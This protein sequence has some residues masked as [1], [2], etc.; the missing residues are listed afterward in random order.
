MTASL[1]KLFCYLIRL[2]PVR[3]AGAIG[4]GIGRTAYLLDK[5]HREIAL[6]NLRR[7]YPER[8][9][10]WRRHIARESFAELGRTMFELPHV[11]L[12]S[13]AFLQSRI[14]FDQKGL[15]EIRSHIES[16][17]GVIFAGCH[18]ANWE[19]GA[20]IPSLCDLPS[21]QLYRTVRQ[22]P[23]EKLMKAWRERFGN[24]LHSRNESIRWLPKAL[25]DGNIVAVM[26]DQHIS[27]GVPI[28]FLGHPANS[29][30]MPAI[31]ARK[32]GT[33]IFAGLFQ[34]VG[35]DFRFRI[36]FKRVELPTTSDD[37]DR[38][39]IE[40]TRLISDSFADTIHSKPEQWL[41][42]H[43]RWLFL[44]EKEAEGAQ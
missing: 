24:R 23:L 2:L 43:R 38:D 29:T 34:R 19:L 17:N 32:Y 3:L 4:A 9:N 35:R 14:D 8:D 28:P 27:N 21:S 10:G 16:G 26:I 40:Y 6:R 15:A 42:V 39:L 5:R 25:K 22:P 37:A 41:W 30:T 33:P 1:F 7:I 20:Q 18:Y 11:F 31:Y 36:D 12:R 13:K 44:D